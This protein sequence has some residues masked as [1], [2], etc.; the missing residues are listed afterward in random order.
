MNS[1]ML[2]GSATDCRNPS[3]KK[4]SRTDSYHSH[5]CT[6]LQQDFRSFVT[7]SFGTLHLLTGKLMSSVHSRPGRKAADTSPFQHVT[8]DMS[9]VTSVVLCVELLYE[10]VWFY[11]RTWDPDRQKRPVGLWGLSHPRCLP[12]N[13]SAIS[14]S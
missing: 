12:S 8:F 5:A 4:R 1:S 9:D 7:Q 3:D 10:H 2:W 13:S 14:W 6:H 11:A